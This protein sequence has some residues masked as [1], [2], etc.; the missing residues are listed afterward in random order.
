MAPVLRG[1]SPIG[2]SRA[3]RGPTKCTLLWVRL[4]KASQCVSFSSRFT[5]FQ[6]HSRSWL[7]HWKAFFPTGET[8]SDALNW[9]A[10]SAEDKKVS[11]SYELK[12]LRQ[13]KTKTSL[14]V[15]C[16]TWTACQAPSSLRLG[17]VCRSAF[18]NKIPAS[19][20]RDLASGCKRAS[21]DSSFFTPSLSLSVLSTSVTN[22]H[23]CAAIYLES[24]S[25]NFFSI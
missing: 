14:S 22:F 13:R 24:S 21:C 5:I 19:F 18:P 20:A 10:C 1:G 4:R 3:L 15:G 8:S 25:K 2:L 7:R 6:R 12:S 16:A 11:S 9:R 17:C 23:T